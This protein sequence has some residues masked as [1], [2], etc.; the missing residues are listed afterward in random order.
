MSTADLVDLHDE[1]LQ[2]IRCSCAASGDA[3]GS[4]SR[5]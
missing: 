1:A 4:P 2:S 5:R 3:G